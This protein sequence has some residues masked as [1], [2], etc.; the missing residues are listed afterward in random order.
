MMRPVRHVL[1]PDSP[2]EWRVLL[3]GRAP[4]W[5][6]GLRSLLENDFEI[7][8]TGEADAIIVAPDTTL[9]E[10]RLMLEQS[11][12]AALI[13]LVDSPV[14][15]Q[16]WRALEPDGFAALPPDADAETLA[17][18]IRAAMLGLIVLAPEFSDAVNI[19]PPLLE[20]FQEHLTPR[21][22]EVLALMS[23]GLSNKIIAR[24]LGIGESTVKFHVS[25]IISKL[26]ASSRTDAVSRGLRAG[27]VAL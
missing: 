22:L 2:L 9:E 23:D 3:L 6:M 12:Q 19:T 4:I 8:E 26:R 13:A 16:H 1:S 11:P 27:L 5:R 17:S 14:Q 18:A 15:V 10:G 21:E 7:I 20:P 25:A 24:R